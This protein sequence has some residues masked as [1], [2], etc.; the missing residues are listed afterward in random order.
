VFAE[1]ANVAFA[2][3]DERPQAPPPK[4]SPLH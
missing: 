1:E 4:I 3:R 2:G